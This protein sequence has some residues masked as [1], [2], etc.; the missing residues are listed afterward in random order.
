MKSTTLK[1]IASALGLSTAAVSLGLRGEGTLSEET[2][3][4]IRDTARRLGYRPNT[5]AAALSSRGG[6]SSKHH[7]PLAVIRQ[8]LTPGGQWYPIDPL[9]D[10]LRQRSHELGYR[11]ESF[12]LE[13]PANFNTLLEMLFRRGFQGLFIAPTGLV[14]LDGHPWDRFAVIACGRYDVASPFHTVRNEV[15]DSTRVA[16]EH[17]AAIGPKR[18]GMFLL[19]HRPP[20]LDDLERRAAAEV[21]RFGRHKPM[22]FVQEADREFLAIIRRHRLEA[23]VGFS[24]GHYYY[25]RNCGLAWARRIPFACLQLTTEF[26]SGPIDGL[27]PCDFECGLAAVQRMDSFI[28]HHE[29]GIPKTPEHIVIRP[30]WHAAQPA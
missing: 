13:T 23:V 22:V 5:F 12:D 17:L 2:R 16:I 18:I 21:L 1:D 10:G 27:A 26:W 9:I 7:I 28:R 14:P 25:L 4:R 30:K 3:K 15:F 11:F 24:I 29:R 20:I 6:R 19:E 8:R